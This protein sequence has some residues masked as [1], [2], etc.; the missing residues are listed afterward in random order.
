MARRMRLSI[1]F[2]LSR[3][4]CS[5]KLLLSCA[6]AAAGKRTLSG[7]HS[8]T[9]VSQESRL[10]ALAWTERVC[11]GDIGCEDQ[12]D[13]RTKPH[14]AD[15]C[16]V[17]EHLA[18]AFPEDELR[19]CQHDEGCKEYDGHDLT[20]RRP[21]EA[22]VPDALIVF[23]RKPA[24]AGS[25]HATNGSGIAACGLLPCTGHPRTKEVRGSGSRL[26]TACAQS[27]KGTDRGH[28]PINV[29][30]TMTVVKVIGRVRKHRLTNPPTGLSL[31]CYADV[32]ETS[33][34]PLPRRNPG[35]RTVT[36]RSGA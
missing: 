27:G 18:Q 5:A 10:Q 26:E 15:R 29:G 20:I 24:C 34:R 22:A 9:S 11:R 13:G 7:H 17:A 31:S 3:A 36:P 25:I 12:R 1:V 19:N 30:C 35:R 2:L 4:C 6:G 23:A 28:G 16:R 8:C 21:Q 14:G 32:P 33:S